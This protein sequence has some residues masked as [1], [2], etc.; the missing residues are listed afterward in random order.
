VLIIIA[1]N[2]LIIPAASVGV[3]RLF[4]IIRDIYSYRR[5]YLKS[6]IIRD[7]IITICIDR[8]LLLKELDNI[9]VIK[10]I[11]EVRLPKELEDQKIFKIKDLEGLINNKEDSI[12]DLNL[13]NDKMAHRAVNEDGEENNKDKESKDFALPALRRAKLS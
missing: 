5:H 11:E 8:F 1:R 13:N 4:N 6:A 2:Y 3:R 7:L 12:E 10:E 9:K